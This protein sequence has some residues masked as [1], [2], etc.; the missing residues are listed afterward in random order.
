[1]RKHEAIEVVYTEAAKHYK[2]NVSDLIKK[3]FR[4]NSCNGYN[5][6]YRNSLANARTIVYMVLFECYG[7]DFIAQ[8]LNTS[9]NSV[10]SKIRKVQDDLSAMDW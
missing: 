5:A 9:L 4:H 6:E 7:S 8:T 10:F 1:M 2:V 3:P